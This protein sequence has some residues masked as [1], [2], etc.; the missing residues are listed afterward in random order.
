MYSNGSCTA[1]MNSSTANSL[2]DKMRVRLDDGDGVFETN[3]SDVVV[4]EVDTFSLSGGRQTIQFTNN[5]AN[6]QMNPSTS[7][8]YWVSLVANSPRGDICLQFDPDANAVMEGKT[9]DF[10]VSISDTTPTNTGSVATI[11]RLQWISATTSHRWRTVLVGLMF[12]LLA[13][14]LA[15][16]HRRKRELI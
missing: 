9:P 7:K 11:V 16:F 4:A 1:P 5:D 10:S 14:L 13:L 6:V 8:T 12:V 15:L 2:L 3:G